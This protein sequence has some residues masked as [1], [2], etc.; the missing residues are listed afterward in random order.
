MMDHLMYNLQ[1]DKQLKER[2]LVQL[3]KI[4][5]FNRSLQVLQLLSPL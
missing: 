1:G 2:Q 4:I 5:T 3:N